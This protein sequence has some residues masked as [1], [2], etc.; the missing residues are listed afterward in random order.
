[1]WNFFPK[2]PAQYFL[3][4]RYFQS[5]KRF[6]SSKQ[7]FQ[8]GIFKKFFHNIF[9]INFILAHQDPTKY[10]TKSW[11]FTVLN[12]WE[13]PCF[14]ILAVF[15]VRNTFGPWSQPVYEIV[16]KAFSKK[17]LLSECLIEILLIGIVTRIYKIKFIDLWLLL[18]LQMSWKK[19]LLAVRKNT[20]L[21]CFWLVLKSLHSS[22][23]R[24]CS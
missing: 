16:F 10:F 5:S 13:I 11:N 14:L 18:S 7:S 12:I 1:M 6:W 17:P 23:L 8:K 3:K 24:P 19:I 21:D 22:T 2:I 20:K 15:T 4:I 9:K